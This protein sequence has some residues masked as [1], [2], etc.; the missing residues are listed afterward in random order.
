MNSSVKYD[1][2]MSFLAF[3]VTRG[4]FFGL[5]CHC[6]KVHKYTFLLLCVFAYISIERQARTQG[7]GGGWG[8]TPPFSFCYVYVFG[9]PPPLLSLEGGF[10]LSF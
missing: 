7:G 4:H 1:H 5:I 9:E 6:E 2:L 8:V 3:Q 10:F